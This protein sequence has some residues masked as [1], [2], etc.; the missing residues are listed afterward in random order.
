MLFSVDQA[1]VGRDEK[2]AFLKTP[3]CEALLSP[4]HY[5]VFREA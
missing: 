3:A 4:T 2:R 1:F 5:K